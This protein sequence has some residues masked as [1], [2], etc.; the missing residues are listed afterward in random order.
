MAPLRLDI[1]MIVLYV[2]SD[3]GTTAMRYLHG[4]LYMQLGIKP[5]YHCHVND[6]YMRTTLIDH[7]NVVVDIRRGGAC[8]TLLF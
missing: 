4:V 1:T 7:T 2:F 3:T 8:Q 6:R 5:L